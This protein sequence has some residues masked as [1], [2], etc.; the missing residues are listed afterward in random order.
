MPTNQ[1]P[2]NKVTKNA[3]QAIWLGDSGYMAGG[4][5]AT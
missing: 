3:I 1:S 4:I 5:Q 2:L